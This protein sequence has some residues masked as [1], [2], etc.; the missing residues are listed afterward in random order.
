PGHGET[1]DRGH[2]AGR[3]C[4]PAAGSACAVT[5]SANSSDTTSPRATR[6][7]LSFAARVAAARYFSARAI[8]FLA[9]PAGGTP[10]AFLVALT[11]AYRS[12]SLR[13]NFCGLTAIPFR[14]MVSWTSTSKVNRSSCFQARLPSG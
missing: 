12:E 3:Y 7:L 14:T 5:A 8:N 2:L 10:P 6:W 1:T 9:L 13:L 11:V 4:A